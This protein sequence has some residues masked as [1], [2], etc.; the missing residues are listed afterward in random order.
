MAARSGM[1]L[2]MGSGKK[3]SKTR[4][5]QLD[6]G[7]LLDGRY[8]VLGVLGRGGFSTVY[9]AEQIQVGRR[10]AVKVLDLGLDVEEESTAVARFLQEA[11]TAARLEHPNVVALY[12]AGVL[13][14]G[15]PFMVL[16]RFK[17]GT[18]K[19]YL[20]K[21]GSM[22]AQRALPLF[23][24]CLDAVAKAHDEG[25]VHR[26][27][28]PSNLVLTDPGE[29]T[30]ALKV[31]DFGIAHLQLEQSD[32]TQ[33][34]ALIG[35]VAYL[36]PEY[37][38]EYKVTP[39]LDVYQLGLVLIEL[40]TGRRAVKGEHPLHFAVG[41]SKGLVQIPDAL[42]SSALGSVLEKATARSLEDRYPNAQ[43]FRDALEGIDAADVPAFDGAVDEVE[44]SAT[45]VWDGSSGTL[46][47]TTGE[48]EPLNTEVQP[49][50]P[51]ALPTVVSTSPAAAAGVSPPPPHASAP[52]AQRRSGLAWA[53]GLVGVGLLAV[54]AVL[55]VMVLKEPPAT[56]PVAPADGVAGSVGLP[57]GA[58]KA[59]SETPAR[60]GA[61]P[62]ASDA[63]P[64]PE[65]D[66]GPVANPDASKAEVA[67]GSTAPPVV[68][69]GADAGSAGGAATPRDDGPKDKGAAAKPKGAKPTGAKP[70][71]TK[72]K[73]G[74]AAKAGKP[75]KPKDTKPADKPDKGGWEIIR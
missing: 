17:G 26:D 43:A 73:D 53:I 55:L 13:D 32:L 56:A 68:A 28:K 25:I 62:A 46:H 27:L 49:G 7:A 41:H 48:I 74:G 19:R 61:V 9:D 1:V 42:R 47:L 39:A 11:R 66:G 22:P 50:A 10:V 63:G 65:A 69:E 2:G 15:R 54:A 59:D 31:I 8:R 60:A 57:P 70:R 24:G 34:G 37:I 5:G 64:G 23:L 44:D 52:P 16:Q 51:P 45:T 33:K 6:K 14:D 21:Q 71:T 4:P 3:V 72:P 12:D 18:L 58:T 30:E 75:D 35:T 29:R 20:R 36:A 40:L 67:D 38:L